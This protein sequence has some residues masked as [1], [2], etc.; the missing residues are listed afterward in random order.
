MCA[1]KGRQ[2]SEMVEKWPQNCVFFAILGTTMN[3]VIP[4]V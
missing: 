4:T 1:K 3:G 2:A